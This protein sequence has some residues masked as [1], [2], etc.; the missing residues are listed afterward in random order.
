MRGNVP[1]ENIRGQRKFRANAFRYLRFAAVGIGVVCNNGVRC[2]CNE[3][4]IGAL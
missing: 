1:L 2:H 4:L 3:I